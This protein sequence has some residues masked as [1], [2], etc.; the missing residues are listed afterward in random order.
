M[1]DF[2]AALDAFIQGHRRCGELA[3]GLDGGRV[4]L[5]CTCGGQIAHPASAPPPA[6]GTGAG[7]WAP[8][9]HDGT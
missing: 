8:D 3:G 2:L 4:W 1:P 5:T 7:G 9:D 6:P